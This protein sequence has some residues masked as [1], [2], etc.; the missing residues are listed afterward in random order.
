MSMTARTT[1]TTKHF[2][3]ISLHLLTSISPEELNERPGTLD[4]QSL[5]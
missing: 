1:K 2:D 3:Y 5:V 4:L